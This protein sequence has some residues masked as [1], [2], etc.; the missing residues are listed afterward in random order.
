MFPGETML[1][2]LEAGDAYFGRRPDVLFVCLPDTGARPRVLDLHQFGLGAAKSCAS[3]SRLLVMWSD[4]ALKSLACT[5]PSDLDR[6]CVSLQL[7]PTR[8]WEAP[9]VVP[10]S[11]V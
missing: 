2:A 10:Q 4:I 3:L 1:Q 7:L 9:M 8:P 6:Q 11:G 5:A